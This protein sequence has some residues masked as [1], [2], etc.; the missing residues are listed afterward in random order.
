MR[1]PTRKGELDRA[2]LAEPEDRHLTSAAIERFKQEVIDLEKRQRPEA[3][4]EVRRLAEMGDFSENFGY[5]NAKALLRRINGRIESLK[6]RIKMAIPIQSGSADG[7]IRLGSTVTVFVNAKPMT[8]ELVGSLETNPS[9]GRISHN[10]PL[11]LALLGHK[12]DEEVVFDGPVG[13]VVYQI[14]EVK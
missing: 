12:A 7:T 13:K 5:Q 6:E 1:I 8:F 14:G 4:A 3:V 10:S 9:R 2:A 11:G